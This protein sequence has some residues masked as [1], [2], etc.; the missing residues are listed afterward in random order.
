MVVKTLSEDTV[1]DIGEDGL[2][3]LRRN[4]LSQ[5]TKYKIYG[6]LNNTCELCGRNRDHLGKNQETLHVHHIREIGEF[7][8]DEDPNM[9]DNIIVLCNRCHNTAHKEKKMAVLEAQVEHRNQK[10]LIVKQLEELFEKDVYQYI[11]KKN[12]IVNVEQDTDF[13]KELGNYSYDNDIPKVPVTT[14]A[15]PVAISTVA[16]S[17]AVRAKIVDSNT[18]FNEKLIEYAIYAVIGLIV[19]ALLGLLVWGAYLLVIYL[20]NQITIFITNN[21]I[22]IVFGIAILLGL[23]SAWAK[24]YD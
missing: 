1:K 19:L 16:V 15:G 6:I 12:P 4:A 23:L 11:V 14:M 17:P 10:L 13:I 20:I 22:L 7:S 2:Y 21:W 5:N 9:P 3:N 8:G 18:N 24:R